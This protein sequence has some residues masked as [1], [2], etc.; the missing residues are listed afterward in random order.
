MADH[1]AKRI[2]MWDSGLLEDCKWGTLDLLVLGHFGIIRGTCLKMA[3]NPQ[4]A[5]L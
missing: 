5:G 2:A 3:I 4:R 1:R